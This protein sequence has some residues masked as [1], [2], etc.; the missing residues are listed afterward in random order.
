MIFG[1]QKTVAFFNGHDV[2]VVKVQ[3]EFNWHWRADADDFLMALEG[4]LTVQIEYRRLS[5]PAAL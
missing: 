3:G 4:Q 1:C 5:N 2:M